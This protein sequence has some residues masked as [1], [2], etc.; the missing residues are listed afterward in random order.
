L[1]PPLRWNP[2]QSF[3]WRQGR[4]PSFGSPITELLSISNGCGSCFSPFPYRF[5]FSCVFLFCGLVFFWGVLSFYRLSGFSL[6]RKCFSSSPGPFLPFLL[7]LVSIFPKSFFCFGHAISSFFIFF[8]FD[9][10]VIV[11]PL[12]LVVL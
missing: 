4:F 12:G 5:S 11:T 8:F 10:I 2:P 6:H 1:T 7:P 9:P 3:P